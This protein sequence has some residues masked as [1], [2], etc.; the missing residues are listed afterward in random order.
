[1]QSHCLCFGYAIILAHDKS[2]VEIV[3]VVRSR[4]ATYDNKYILRHIIVTDELDPEIGRQIVFLLEQWK[5]KI[6]FI[7]KHTAIDASRSFFAAPVSAVM[8]W[9]IAIIVASFIILQTPVVTHDF[10]SVFIL[11]ARIFVAQTRQ[12]KTRHHGNSKHRTNKLQTPKE[13]YVMRAVYI[14][15]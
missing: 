8:A 4:P 13:L 9:V 5:C 1:M 14:I 3:Y 12:Q 15:K 11:V 2:I 6:L 10:V 7:S